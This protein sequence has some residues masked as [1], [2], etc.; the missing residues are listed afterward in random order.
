M[1]ILVEVDTRSP[2][3]TLVPYCRQEIQATTSMTSLEDVE[4]IIGN[5]PLSDGRGLKTWAVSYI[6]K[7][8][9]AGG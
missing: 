1:K 4:A 3:V 9:G 6:R 7:L 5:R 2:S 8:I